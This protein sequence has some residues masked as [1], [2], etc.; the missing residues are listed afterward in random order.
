[1]AENITTTEKSYHEAVSEAYREALLHRDD[2]FLI[3]ED[4]TKSLS[5]LSVGLA[6]EFGEERVRDTP[7]SE[8][9]FHGLGIGAAMAGKRPIVEHEINTLS[10]ISMDQIVNNANKLRYMTG[11]QVSIP[12]TISI[13]GSGASGGSAAQ[14]SD[15]PWP[16]LLNCGVK[17]V[18]PS[19]PYDAKGLFHAAVA[20]NDPVAVFFPSR[21]MGRTGEVPEDRYAVSLG[22]AD[23]KRE[24]EDV[25][26][27]AVGETVRDALDAAEE[28][29]G[30][31]SVEVVDPRTLLPLDEETIFA[32]VR[33]TGR[34]V[35]ADG[36]NRTCGAA[37]EI[38]ARVANHCVWTLDAPIKRV[39][40]ADTTIS[41]S[42]PEERHVLPDAETIE[43]AVTDI[44]Y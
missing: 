24:G 44:V 32:S 20:E 11:G 29:S 37:A 5:G 42:P 9:A 16:L 26:V 22:E 13:P 4:V 27:I 17:T 15:N 34:V 38:A 7:I 33:K 31:V 39:T 41:Y 3:G 10:Y 43:R 25:T 35:V 19:T 6:D 2:T 28:L 8:Q 36:A 12:L 30:D 18:V 40:R 1:M 14:H 21:L 23:V